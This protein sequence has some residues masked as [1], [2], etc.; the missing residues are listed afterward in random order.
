MTD[1]I[2]QKDI[3]WLE[4]ALER[5]GND[6]SILDIS[7]LD[8]YLC[9][10]VSSPRAIDPSLWL[11]GIFAHKDPKW[12]NEQEF[13]RFVGTVFNIMHSIESTLNDIPDEFEP[14]FLT[15][16]DDPDTLLVE[17]WCFGY[18]KGVDVGRWPEIE[19]TSDTPAQL[20]AI[21]LFGLTDNFAEL[22]KLSGTELEQA[23]QALKPAAVSLHQYWFERRDEFAEASQTIINEGP[24]V[25]RNDPCPCGSGK[26]FK[27]CCL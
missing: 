17:E 4:K 10:I 12:P 21:G 18:M 6:G 25:S 3:T 5:F 1:T 26:K 19:P 15:E 14:V 22:D 9:A 7:E 16:E 2:T 11:P 27:K 8:G 23:K 24:K 20:D 13:E